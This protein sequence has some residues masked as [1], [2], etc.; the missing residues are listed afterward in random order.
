[1]LFSQTIIWFK[2]LTEGIEPSYSQTNNFPPASGNGLPVKTPT[3]NEM[4]ISKPW[5]HTHPLPDTL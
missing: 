5:G 4:N 2:K 1:M 3:R